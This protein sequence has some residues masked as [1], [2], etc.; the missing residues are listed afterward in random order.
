MHYQKYKP[1]P[2]LAPFVECY[3]DWSTDGPLGAPLRIESPPTGFASMVFTYSDPYQVRVGQ[4]T[5]V[6]PPAFL[7]GQATQQYELHV[8][9]R[10]GMTGIVFRPAGLSTLF[11]LPMHE[12][13]DQRLPLADVLGT[14]VTYLYEQLGECPTSSGR[15]ALLEQFLNRQFLRRGDCFDR[16]DFA[17]NLIVDKF[18]VLTVNELLDELYV[19]R[20]QFERQ[21]LQKVGVSPKYYARIRRVGY[22]CAQLA[23]QR[24]Q[25]H[26]WQDFIFRAGYY[27]QSHFIREFT[28]FTG[29]RP[30]LYVKDNVELS[31]YL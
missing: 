24:W 22:V 12:F 26:D 11:G 23:T 29:K 10:I 2:Y 28:Q 31:H 19:C 9:G 17:A 18:G 3:F 14:S 15:A 5:T 20:R 27:D 7:T 21:F 25:I 30:T 1:A 4:H 16:T 13:T 6:A 8:S